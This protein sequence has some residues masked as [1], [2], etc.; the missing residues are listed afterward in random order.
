MSD[1]AQSFFQVYGPE[2]AHRSQCPVCDKPLP[3]Q[4][5]QVDPFTMKVLHEY[6]NADGIILHPDGSISSNET[7]AMAVDDPATRITGKRKADAD[8]YVDSDGGLGAGAGAGAVGDAAAAAA[9]APRKKIK[10]DD[11][12]V[13]LSSDD[14]G[15]YGSDEEAFPFMNVTDVTADGKE[16]IWID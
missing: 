8:E 13:V 2:D 1:I 7:T 12:V 16:V 5:L 3:P 10:T 14:D 9:A 15:D 6:P 4:D 11:G